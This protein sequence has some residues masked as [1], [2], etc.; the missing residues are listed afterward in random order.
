ME[1][2]ETSYNFTHN[3]NG[4][5]Q[6]ALRDWQP[7]GG[8]E[9]CIGVNINSLGYPNATEGINATIAVQAAGGDGNLFQVRFFFYRFT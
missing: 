2:P 6:P 4:T 7:V 9:I 3:L 5:S 8:G 1:N